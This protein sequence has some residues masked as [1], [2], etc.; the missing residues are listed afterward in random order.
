[1]RQEIKNYDEIKQ[2]MNNML[3]EVNNFFRTSHSWLSFVT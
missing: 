1:M 3:T 2:D